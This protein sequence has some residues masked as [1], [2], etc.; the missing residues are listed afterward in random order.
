MKGGDGASLDTVAPL[1]NGGSPSWDFH[2]SDVVTTRKNQPASP[3]PLECVR[4]EM[5]K[6]CEKKS[7]MH[8]VLNEVYL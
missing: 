8:E 7:R 4:L 3:L 6:L 5:K 1:P 2:P